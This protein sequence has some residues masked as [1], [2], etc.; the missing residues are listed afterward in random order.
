MQKSDFYVKVVMPIL[1]NFYV[2]FQAGVFYN[3]SGEPD[4][5]EAWLFYEGNV[6]E[7]TSRYLAIIKEMVIRELQELSGRQPE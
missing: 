4:D 5:P 7:L 6:Y 1:K 2:Y 3:F